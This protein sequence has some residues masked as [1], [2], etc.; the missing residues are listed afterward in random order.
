M[1]MMN[2]MNHATTLYKHRGMVYELSGSVALTLVAASF[3]LGMPIQKIFDYALANPHYATAAVATVFEGLKHIK[4]YVYPVGGSSAIQKPNRKLNYSRLFRAG[5]AATAVAYGVMQLYNSCQGVSDGSLGSMACSAPGVAADFAWN[6]FV[7]ALI[8]ANILKS[9]VARL[10]KMAQK[11]AS[12]GINIFKRIAS[13]AS[14]F[15]F[16]GRV[17]SIFGKSQQ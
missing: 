12:S 13:A 10:P 15:N 6:H 7:L 3:G 11:V 9:Q 4:D 1:D 17:S 2:M 16:I 8:G 5:A 14:S